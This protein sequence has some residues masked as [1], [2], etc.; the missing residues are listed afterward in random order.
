MLR[1]QD[2]NLAVVEAKKSDKNYKD[3]LQQSIAYGRALDVE[4]VYS[5][6][7]HK[8]LEYHIPTG[9]NKDIEDFPTPQELFER[10]YPNINTQKASRGYTRLFC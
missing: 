1:Y 8:I 7:G 3:G 10:K 9:Q 5:T 6:N 2:I 4:F